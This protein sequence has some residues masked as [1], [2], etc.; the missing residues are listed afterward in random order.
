MN[1]G[2]LKLLVGTSCITTGTD[3]KAVKAI[4]YLQGGKSEIQVKQCIGRGTR[5]PEG[6]LDCYFIDFDVSNIDVTHRHAEGRKKIYQDVYPDFEE[7]RL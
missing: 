5:K 7:L 3:I 2:K 4:I 1:E 6:K